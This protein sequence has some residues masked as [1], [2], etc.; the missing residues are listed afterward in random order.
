MRL[1]RGA[2]DFD[3]LAA[4]G[5]WVLR[6][7]RGAPD[8]GALAGAAAAIKDHRTR[9]VDRRTAV[10]P[11]ER[12]GNGSRKGD[13]FNG[14]CYEAGISSRLRLDAGDVG[15]VDG[16]G[17]PVAEAVAS[18]A[19][20]TWLRCNALPPVTNVAT[21]LALTAE[22]IEERANAKADFYPVAFDQLEHQ[23]TLS[24]PHL[25]PD[26]TGWVPAEEVI[27][28]A[29]EDWWPVE[30]VGNGVDDSA[31]SVFAARDWNERW[32]G[33]PGLCFFNG[34]GAIV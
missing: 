33:Y 4:A 20:R 31:R 22:V 24:P 19:V 11:T 25:S 8:F 12:N 17:N 29:P 32:V 27:A 5:V 10:T 7:S 28:G 34:Y 30:L 18:V 16:E 15:R 1:S 13:R 14:S 3:T 23:D 21:L 2:P 6:L 26:Q 9:T